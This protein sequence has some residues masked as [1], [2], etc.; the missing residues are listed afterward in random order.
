MYVTKVIWKKQPSASYKNYEYIH[1]ISHDIYN[2]SSLT[3]MH[4]INFAGI[5]G[6]TFSYFRRQ[7]IFTGTFRWL[8]TALGLLGDCLVMVARDN[9]VVCDLGYDQKIPIMDFD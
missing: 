7:K 6:I 3:Q 9:F 2:M 8:H 4:Y 1:R 5:I